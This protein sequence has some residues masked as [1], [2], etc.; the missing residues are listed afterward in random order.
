MSGIKLGAAKY[1]VLSE[2]EYLNK[3][4]MKNQLEILKLANLSAQT[5]V[6]F[7]WGA[8]D[9]LTTEIGRFN[10]VENGEVKHITVERGSTDEAVVGVE[11]QPISALIT[12]ETLKDSLKAAIAKYIHDEDSSSGELPCLH[13]FSSVLT[14]PILPMHFSWPLCHQLQQ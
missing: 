10:E 8:K 5:S 3:V 12:L 9:S 4:G 14:L 1:Q 11:F 7:N 13:V 6:I 2:E